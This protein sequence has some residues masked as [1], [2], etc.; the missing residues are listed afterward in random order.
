MSKAVHAPGSRPFGQVH[1]FEMM[2]G[3]PTRMILVPTICCRTP[4]PFDFLNLGN[5]RVHPTCGN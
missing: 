5:L 4:L 3:S 1:E 2:R